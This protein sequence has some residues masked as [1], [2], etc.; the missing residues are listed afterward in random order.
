V[1]NVLLTFSG[2]KFHDTTARIIE[3]APRFGVDRVWVTDDYWLRHYRPAYWERV[4]WFREHPGVR[5]VDWFCFKPYV[6]GDFFRRLAPGDVL[7]Y[8]D[9]DTYPVADLSPL[10][11]TC[12]RDGGAMLFGAR[13][14]TNRVWTKRD[15][16]ILMGC[17]AP[18]YW[19]PW[20]TVARFMLFEKGAA[21]PA[22][23]FLGQ[24]LGFTANPLVNTFDP[25]VLA[26]DYPELIEPRCEQ[27][28]LSNLR[29][30]YGLPIYR[31]ACEFGVWDT[32]GPMA[33]ERNDQGYRT[34]S[35]EGRHSYRPG[36]AGDE[37]EGSAFRNVTE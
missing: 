32:E 20:Q 23:Q 18:E 28:V 31:E 10:Y 9:A 34:F 26:P 24:W 27:S 21:F 12:R 14:C 17:D 33:C 3:D 7:L 13:G 25:S 11:Q 16:F 8:T 5:G 30:R 36:Y 35:Q 6:I 2:A 29:I 4:R 37:S 19:E 1:A 22:E 15:A